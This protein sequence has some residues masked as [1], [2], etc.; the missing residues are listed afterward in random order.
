MKSEQIGELGKALVLAQSQIKHAI[1]DSANPFFKSKY[2]DLTSVWEA[3]REALNKNGLSIVQTIDCGAT[4]FDSQNRTSIESNVLITTLLHTS[5]QWI[6]GRCPLLNSKGDMQGL[7]SAISY[8]RRYGLAA[9]IGVTAED[10]DANTADNKEN[11][12]TRPC[13]PAQAKMISAKLNA[14]GLRGADAFDFLNK[15]GT[16]LPERL[17]AHQI[18][19]VIEAIDKYFPKRNPKDPPDRE[20]EPP[21]DPD[22]PWTG[23][24]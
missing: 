7:G 8:A 15:F 4:T 1:K 16:H 3:C 2:A 19:S 18:N 17:Y 10:D 12:D 11:S 9:I 14:K 20:E 6:E 23:R 13:S 21:F 24:K 5:G 22:I